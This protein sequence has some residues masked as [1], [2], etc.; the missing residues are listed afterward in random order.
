MSKNIIDFNRIRASTVVGNLMRLLNFTTRKNNRN[1]LFPYT[2]A[3]IF[4]KSIDLSHITLFYYQRCIVGR[5]NYLSH[6]SNSMSNNIFIN[7]VDEWYESDE[8]DDE[9]EDYEDYEEDCII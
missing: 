9:D 2:K 4:S 7:A 6:G 5:Y 1:T 8:D 3:S